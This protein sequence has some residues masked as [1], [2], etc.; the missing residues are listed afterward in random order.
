MIYYDIVILNMYEEKIT[1]FGKLQVKFKNRF[2]WL[3][4]F[5]ESSKVDLS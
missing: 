5:P 4:C 1:I 2:K 3:L